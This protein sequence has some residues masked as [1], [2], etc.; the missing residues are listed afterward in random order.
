MENSEKHHSF[1]AAEQQSQCEEEKL[2][3]STW[4]VYL[5]LFSIQS[6]KCTGAKVLQQGK[7]LSWALEKAPELI[8]G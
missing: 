5:S 3:S 1:P 7:R 8:P 4:N 2:G 6:H